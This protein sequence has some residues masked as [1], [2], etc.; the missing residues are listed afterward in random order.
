MS[1]VQGHDNGGLSK[2]FTLAQT[3][4]FFA[5]VG[6]GHGGDRQSPALF[7]VPVSRN[8]GHPE[9]RDGVVERRLYLRRQNERSDRGLRQNGQ[10]Q[11]IHTRGKIRDHER[12]GETRRPAHLPRVPAEDGQQVR[13]DGASMPDGQAAPGIHP[14]RAHRAR[15]GDQRV[16]GRDRPGGL[17]RRAPAI[18]PGQR[19]PAGEKNVRGT[20]TAV[21][22]TAGRGVVRARRRRHGRRDGPRRGAGRGERP[23]LRARAGVQPSIPERVPNETGAGEV[24]LPR[25]GRVPRRALSLTNHPPALTCARFCLSGWI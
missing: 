3:A 10:L 16:G 2:G 22:V 4:R 11:E 5:Y 19:R 14:K 20:Y 18:K 15:V 8:S 13:A 17:R 24:A 9:D 1:D 7:H 21:T 6:P 12:Q 25:N 23:A